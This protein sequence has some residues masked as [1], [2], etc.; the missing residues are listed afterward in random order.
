MEGRQVGSCPKDALEVLPLVVEHKA[1]ILVDLT[2]ENIGKHKAT[3][4]L[5]LSDW[6]QDVQNF[7]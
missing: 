2:I 4:L 6:L 1:K 3:V 5:V 7:L